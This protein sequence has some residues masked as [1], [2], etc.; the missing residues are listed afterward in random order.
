MN[1]IKDYKAL[2]IVTNVEQGAM[3]KRLM[4]ENKILKSIIDFQVKR[5]DKLVELYEE[6]EGEFTDWSSGD[7]IFPGFQELSDIMDKL[8]DA[9]LCKDTKYWR[10]KENKI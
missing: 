3:V 5:Y 9:G 4:E 1:T 2:S 6:I 8:V 7:V 10:E